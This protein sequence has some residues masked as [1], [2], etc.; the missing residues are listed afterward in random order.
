M[1]DGIWTDFGFKRLVLRIFSRFNKFLTAIIVFKH[2]NFNLIDKFNFADLK[3]I[4][5]WSPIT[6]HGDTT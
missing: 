5:T 3:E 1:H 2:K 4:G 6:M